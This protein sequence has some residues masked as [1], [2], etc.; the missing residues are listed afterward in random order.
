MAEKFDEF[1]EEVQY[2][3]RQERL[4]NLWDRYGKLVII[5]IVGI[6]ILGSGYNFWRHYETNK[7]SQ[8]A[9]QLTSA[10]E[11]LSA[12]ETEKALTV[13]GVLAQEGNTTYQPLALFQKAGTLLQGEKSAK[14]LEAIAIYNQLSTNAKLDPLWRDLATLLAVMASIDQPTLKGEDLL[15]RLSALTVDQNPWRYFAREMKG[16]LLQRKGD[17]VQAAEVFA[18]LVQDNQTPSGISMRARLMVQILSTDFE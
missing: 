14:P 15:A 11:Y 17:S 4:I 5:G 1:L 16:L 12:G 7:R 8:M 13:M 6:L 3:I 9:D 2:D 18:A 10:Q